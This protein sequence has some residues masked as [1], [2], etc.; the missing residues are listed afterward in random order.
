[1]EIGLMFFTGYFEEGVYVDNMKLIGI[2]FDFR[3]ALNGSDHQFHHFSCIET[4]ARSECFNMSFVPWPFLHM[5]SQ[6]PAMS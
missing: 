2:D 1:M 4:Q 6:Q 3:K 5:H